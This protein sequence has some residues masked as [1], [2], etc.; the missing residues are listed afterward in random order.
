MIEVSRANRS[1]HAPREQWL[2]A[3]ADEYW[4]GQQVFTMF[5][6]RGY[7]KNLFFQQFDAVWAFAVNH[8]QV[9]FKTSLSLAEICAAGDRV[10]KESLA[11]SRSLSFLRLA[12][13]GYS[14]IRFRKR[15]G[16]PVKFTFLPSSPSEHKALVPTPVSAPAM[17]G[18]GDGRG[19]GLG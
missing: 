1:D 10:N 8:T 15:G 4:G 16:T 12:Q 6:T 11:R 14:D 13:D 17:G 5:T 19:A 3:P 2:V 7:N 9:R 18:A